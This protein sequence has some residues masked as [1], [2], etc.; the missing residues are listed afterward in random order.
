LQLKAFIFLSSL[1]DVCGVEKG[2]N[3]GT[4]NKMDIFA[5]TFPIHS[6]SVNNIIA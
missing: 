3:I 6:L 2:L 4:L 1:L 5:H